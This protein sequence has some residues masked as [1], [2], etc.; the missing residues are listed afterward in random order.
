M[1]R[2]RILL[3]NQNNF[4]SERLNSSVLALYRACIDNLSCGIFQTTTTV[5]MSE[6][7]QREVERVVEAVIYGCP[8][9]F[10]V[11]Q[12]VQTSWSGDQLT[13]AFT[14]KYPDENISELWDKLVTELDRI[15]AIVNK[16]EKQYDRINRI[17][18]YLCARVKPVN[19]TRGRFGD[20]YGALILKE[21]RCEGFAKAAKL[22]MDRCGIQSVIA[23]GEAVFMGHRERHAWII[24]NCDG[25]D[26]HFDFTWNAT[27]GTHNIPG[28]DYMFLDDHDIGI[29]H[30]PNYD[31]PRC[32]DSTKTFWA[33]NNGI[34]KY[35]SEL[36]R[37]KIVAVKNNYIAAAKLPQKLTRYEVDNEVADWMRNELSAYSY[38]SSID[39]SY[40]EA[41]DLLVFYFIN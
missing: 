4:Y 9:L 10:F 27:K 11:E 30:F 6:E 12:E 22:I 37:I 21:A 7:N 5:E 28:I 13:L 34:I 36:S 40:N 23:C 29:E 14:N 16:F 8:E 19:S 39:Y 1:P 41:L 20:A 3:S 18:Q 17:N 35:H 33:Q 2:I 32:F 25:K 31:Y 15:S 26:Y 24:A 38:G